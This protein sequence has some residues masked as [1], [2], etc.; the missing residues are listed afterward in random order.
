MTS[1]RIQQFRSIFW[2]DTKLQQREKSV[3]EAGVLKLYPKV[4][5]IPQ[6]FVS[7]L[8]EELELH[9]G[10]ITLV[11]IANPSSTKPRGTLPPLIPTVE[12][13]DGLTATDPYSHYYY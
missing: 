7:A 11:W 13:T 9:G 4:L 10:S 8:L 3:S 2:A 12:S 1:H 5:V 6:G